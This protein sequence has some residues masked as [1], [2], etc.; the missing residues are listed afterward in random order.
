M[1]D[2]DVVAAAQ[3]ERFSRIKHDPRCRSTPSV[4]A[5]NASVEPDG[6][7]AVVYYDKPLTTFNR[8][9]RSYAA[10]GIRGVTTFPSAMQEWMGRKLWVPF[11]VE[12]AILDLG[13]KMPGR[14]LFAEHHVSHA[15]AFYPSPFEQAAILTFDG[16]GEWATSSV[17]VGRG[18]KVEL[19]REMRFPDSIGLL[20]SAFTAFC[21][22]KVNSGEYKLMGL[23]PFGRPTH[24]DTIL[25]ELIELR[26]DGSFV[27]NL[28]YFDFLAGK[29][30]TNRRFERL[31]GGP[32]RRP[33]SPSPN[34]NSTWRRPSR[35]SP[36]RSCCGWRF[37]H[38]LTG[39]DDVVLGGGVALNCVA[40]GRLLREGPFQRVWVQPAAGDAGNA[41]GCALWA[42]HEVLERPRT[43]PVS[44]SA[45]GMHGCQLGTRY[46][47]DAIA[48]SLDE[49]CRPHERLADEQELADRIAGLIADGNVVG[50]FQG[51]MEFGPRALGNRSILADPRDQAMQA[52]VNLAIKKRESF[53]PFAPAVLADKASE[54]FD[55]DQPS[56]YMMFVAPVAARHLRTA[57]SDDDAV[58]DD[59]STARTDLQARLAAIDSDIGAVTHIDG[60]ARVQTVD[61]DRFGALHR[62]L[63]AFDRRTG[64]PVLVN[65]SFNV[66]GEPI[67]E[68]PEDAYR[69]FMTT[70][71]DVLVLE[72]CVLLKAD[73]P[74][75]E[76]PVPEFAAD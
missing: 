5:S 26:D 9:M 48:A 10:A 45:D 35:T 25:N 51:R 31:F 58:G 30:M 13:Y 4:S 66:R 33:E 23:A 15:A 7:D 64:C 67:V 74:P 55:L 50:Y 56:P 2:G 65:T 34:A 3:Q 62:L 42:Y 11:E 28:R 73:Q 53:R 72:D 17:G 6:L 43:M 21:G 69:C 60:S 37:A 75:Y 1:V 32:A 19:L 22:F 49:Q 20:Y 57:G 24:R 18:A 16:V 76:G 70:D 12:R 40:N 52:K 27:M 59:P 54:W 61:A 63:T 41:I 14:L 71:M 44:A 47:P 29:R 36:R 8:I 46:D 68:S 39:D 38:S